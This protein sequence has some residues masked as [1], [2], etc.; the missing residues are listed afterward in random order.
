MMGVSDAATRFADASTLAV[1]IA[2]LLLRRNSYDDSDVAV[3]VDQMA[4]YERIDHSARRAR[5][6]AGPRPLPASDV[7]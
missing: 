6:P 3:P 4:P 2:Y 5:R 7:P 1:S